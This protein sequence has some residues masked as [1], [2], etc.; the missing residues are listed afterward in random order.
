MNQ[1]RRS[2]ENNPLFQAHLRLASKIGFLAVAVI[3]TEKYD[4]EHLREDVRPPKQAGEQYD[5]EGHSGCDIYGIWRWELWRPSDLISYLRNIAGWV[6]DV[7]ELKSWSFA[8]A[9]WPFGMYH[10]AW[11]YSI[12]SMK[13]IRFD[14]A[15]EVHIHPLFTEGK[16]YTFADRDAAFKAA[17]DYEKK[18]TRKEVEAMLASWSYTPVRSNVRPVPAVWVHGTD[19]TV[20]VVDEAYVPFDLKDGWSN[21]RLA[22]I[23]GLWLDEFAGIKGTEVRL[24]DTSVGPKDGLRKIIKNDYARRIKP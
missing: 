12:S 16:K 11:V 7:W 4:H 24:V 6:K 22:H 5:V 18:M 9:T 14:V 10:M 15:E 23:V 20:M 3:H 19:P 2:L 21:S 17:S 1:L 8:R 13:D